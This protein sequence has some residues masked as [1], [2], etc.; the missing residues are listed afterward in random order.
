MSFKVGTV[1]H[2]GTGCTSSRTTRPARAR[3]CHTP[4]KSGQR[5]RI[6]SRFWRQSTQCRARTRRSFSPRRPEPPAPLRPAG[7][8]GCGLTRELAAAGGP[9]NIRVNA[10]CPGLIRSPATEK[11]TQNPDVLDTVLGHQ[12]IQRIGQPEDV[13]RAALF[14]LSDHAS[15]IT[16]DHIMVDGGYTII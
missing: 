5:W 8:S 6:R 16:G 12:I 7:R 15:F 11:L 4:G 9:H 14:L 2:G 10:I 13:V 1:R 3:G